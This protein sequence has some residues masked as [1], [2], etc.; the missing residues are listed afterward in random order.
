MR[1]R[2]QEKYDKLKTVLNFFTKIP[3]SY[4]KSKSKITEK[5]KESSPKTKNSP[6]FFKPKTVKKSETQEEKKFFIS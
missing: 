1:M 3:K 5:S 6:K 4:T 2:T